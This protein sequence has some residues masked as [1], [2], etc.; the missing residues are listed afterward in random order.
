MR[1]M[2][3]VSL[4]LILS[5]MASPSFAVA[6]NV[7]KVTRIYT[8]T[9]INDVIVQVESPLAGCADGFWLRMSDTGAKTVYSQVLAAQAANTPLQIT[10]AETQLW[11]Q[12]ATGQFCRLSVV[13]T[14]T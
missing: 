11:P 2:T 10:A 4:L 12:S 14:L 3:T 7:G 6:G 8:Y 1:T 5:A 13:A 9:D